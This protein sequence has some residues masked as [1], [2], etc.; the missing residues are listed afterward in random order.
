MSV[1]ISDEIKLIF[2]EKETLKALA[3]VDKHGVPHVVFKGSIQVAP[4]GH[5]TYLEILESSQTNKN[6]T[7]ALWFDKQVTINV[8]S[9]ERRSFQIKGKPRKVHVAGPLFEQKYA[10]VTS[11]LP[12]ADLSG[13][14]EIEPLEVREQTFPVRLAQQKRDFPFIGHLDQD[15]K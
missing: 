2:A 1:E 11:R 14:W 13:V 12:E 9:K 6:L 10:E 4:E 7:Y 15:L 3:S 5:I 8:V